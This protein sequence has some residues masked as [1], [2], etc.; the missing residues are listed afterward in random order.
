MKKNIK[1]LKAFAI[2]EK[3]PKSTVPIPSCT[4]KRCKVPVWSVFSTEQEAKIV[5]SEY[6]AWE[7]KH[8]RKPYEVEIKPIEINYIPSKIIK[9]IKKKK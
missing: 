7:K 1:T 8:K 5:I 2:F 3:I 9:I 4:L 6:I